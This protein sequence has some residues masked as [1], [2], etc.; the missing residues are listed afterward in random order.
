MGDTWPPEEWSVT[1]ESFDVFCPTCNIQ[2][3]ARAI[4]AGR[5]G[6]SGN[7]VNPLDETETEYYGDTYSVALCPRCNAPFLMQQSRYGVVG[8][9]ET[10]TTK[11]VLY[12]TT[13][14]LP[15]EGI[16]EP[17]G[18]AYQQALRCFSGSSYEASALMCRR[19]LEA[20][21]KSFAAS[22]RSLQAKLDALH[23]MEVIDKRLT[24]WAHG[25]RAIGNEAAHDT[26]TE[27]SKDDARDALDFTEA[28]LM[29]VFAL[30]ARFA[31]FSARRGQP[32]ARPTEPEL[33]PE[34][35]S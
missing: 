2:V 23:A 27:L 33:T 32:N 24:Q 10:V 31:A 8:E 11:I 9:F 26:D 18:R 5:G 25:V 29:Y 22:G 7:A 21:C 14:R 1:D 17:V 34:A 4:C 30:N 13:S 28:L 3:Q 6:F 19:S 20:L 35:S 16:P 12:P 15:A